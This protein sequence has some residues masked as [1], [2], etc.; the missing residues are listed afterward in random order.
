MLKYALGTGQRIRSLLRSS[1]S[2]K[3]VVWNFLG[4]FLSGVLIVIATP[5]Y[6]RHLGLE[7]YGIVGL[8]LMMQVM[9]GLLDVGMG[10]T[11]V[12]EFA[13]S[14]DDRNSQ[15][16]RRD[17]LRTL[18]I[19]YWIL[20]AF[21][22]LGLQLSAGPIASHWLKSGTMPIGYIS[23]AI[24]LMALT[25]G[26]QFP[27]ALYSNG[28]AGL[29]EHGRMN[30]LQVLGNCLRYGSGVAVLFWRSDLV[31]FFA[32]QAVVAG[33]QTYATRRMLWRMLSNGVTRPAVY[34]KEMFQRLW[35]FSTGMA[36]TA[37]TSVLLANADRLVL[38]RMM[39]T[40]ELGKYAVA[41]T[42]SGLLQMGIQPFYRSFF[43]RYSELFSSGD[44]AQLR[45][46]YFRSCRL[47]AAVLIPLGLI[48]W[49]FAPQL[50]HAWLG[51]DDQTIVHV[52]RWLLAGITSSGLM[53]LPAAFQQAHGRTGLHVA[54]MAGALVLG[55]PVMIWAIQQYGTAGATAVWI[56]H[57]VSGLT[58]ELWIMHRKLL[59]GD[60][61]RWYRTTILPPLLLALPI[62]CVSWWLLP[63]DLSRWGNLGWVSLTGLL[64][65]AVTILYGFDR[66]RRDSQ[67]V[68]VDEQGGR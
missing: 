1:R 51:R 62:V 47:L 19:V 3:N 68:M 60:L 66:G 39:P 61:L 11:L 37:L 64:A 30:A 48:G 42:A 28:M 57:G 15:E 8:W 41:F 29:Q 25:L 14:R 22:C 59:V 53:W 6:L 33:A 65:V 26:M 67:P 5:I 18:E 23:H 21:L 32:V 43:P 38:S 50:F 20:A 7:G 49:I 54:M 13:D 31:W 58:L 4:G 34:R 10:A 55:L 12:R 44:T 63:L 46:E 9:M 35:R 2:V 27:C 40:A 52:F 56:I 45:M 36:A 16:S 24:Q 17:L